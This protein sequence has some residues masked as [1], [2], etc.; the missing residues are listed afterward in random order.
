MGGIRNSPAGSWAAR[1][2]E[3]EEKGRMRG[4]EKETSSSGLLKPGGVNGKAVG[5]RGEAIRSS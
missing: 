2:E 5:E 4:K 3:R 1:S